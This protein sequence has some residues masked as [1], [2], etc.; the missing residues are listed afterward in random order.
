MACSDNSSKKKKKREKKK[1]TKDDKEEEE[2]EEE[3]EEVKIV[4]L[5]C[6]DSMITNE[7]LVKKKLK[8]G[9]SFEAAC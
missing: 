5:E 6:K 1:D 3:G 9:D 7:Y 2:E 4:P 8:P